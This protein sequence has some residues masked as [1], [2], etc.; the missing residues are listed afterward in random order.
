MVESR[1]LRVITRNPKGGCYNQSRGDEENALR[2]SVSIAMPFTEAC[3]G[4]TA[5]NDEHVEDERMW[6][7]WKMV[8]N[9]EV[10]MTSMGVK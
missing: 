3:G 8:R 10:E 5:N 4:K 7:D 2:K 6:T 1:F 9:N